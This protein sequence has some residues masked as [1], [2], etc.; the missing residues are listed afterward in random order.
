MEIYCAYTE[1]YVKEHP[2]MFIKNRERIGQVVGES[3]DKE[4]WYVIW[5]NTRT[6][7][8]LHKSHVFAV[9]IE[10]DEIVDTLAN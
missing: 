4:C 2:L 1:D 6:R 8:C 5:D 7:D 3:R 10:T 9:N